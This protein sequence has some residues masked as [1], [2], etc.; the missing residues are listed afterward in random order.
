MVSKIRCGRDSATLTT[1][2]EHLA[3]LLLLVDAFSDG[4]DLILDGLTKLAKLDFLLR[5]PAFLEELNTRR[6]LPTPEDVAARDI[7]HRA[8]SEPMIRYRYGPWDRR[9]YV[10]VGALVGRG[11]GEYADGRGAVALRLTPA[12]RRL[13]ESLRSDPRWK[14]IWRRVVFLHKHYDE[15]G[16]RLKE[17]IYSNFPDLVAQQLGSGIAPSPGEVIK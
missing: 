11:L 12:G 10:L 13:A 3:R 2:D 1:N 8:I 17:R 15:P 4:P 6:E 7:E 9:Y 5:Y 14:P 16:N